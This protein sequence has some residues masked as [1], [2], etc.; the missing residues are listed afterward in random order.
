VWAGLGAGDLCLW[1]HRD[2][3]G[4]HCSMVKGIGPFYQGPR[5]LFGFAE[6]RRGHLV[7]AKFLF[8]MWPQVA[9]R[10]LGLLRTSHAEKPCRPGPWVEW[11]CC[12]SVDH[13][14]VRGP[15]VAGQAE[16]TLTL[17]G[18]GGR[19]SCSQ[20]IL[21][22]GGWFG[23]FFSFPHGFFVSGPSSTVSG[24]TGSAINQC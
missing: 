23:V 16:K 11:P 22:R 12:H 14:A 2:Y 9:F 18:T 1:A 6:I 3:L 10:G 15:W 13:L 17:Q 20:G 4:G 24:R 7:L 8:L 19:H 5:V 21:A